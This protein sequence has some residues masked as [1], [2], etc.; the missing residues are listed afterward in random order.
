MHKKC[1]TRPQCTRTVIQL[2]RLDIPVLFNYPGCTC[3]CRHYQP[4]DEE[5][6]WPWHLGVITGTRILVSGC[7][8]IKTVMISR[9]LEI[10]ARP[11]APRREH[12]NS[13]KA[14]N[15]Y[16]VLMH[17]WLCSRSAISEPRI[18]D[19]DRAITKKATNTHQAR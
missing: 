16:A 7:Y 19:L 13:S 3:V 5:D 4:D 17:T 1:C 8:T 11:V 2:L 6:G 18:R 10:L 9:L 14:K 12:L 15:T